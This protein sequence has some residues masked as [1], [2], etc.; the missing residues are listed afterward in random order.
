L[1][2]NFI[3]TT[4]TNLN[5][6]L[7]SQTQLLTY[8]NH[9]AIAHS[10]L[11]YLHSPTTFRRYKNGELESKPTPS[12]ILGTM[13]EDY[14]V[15]DE[16]TFH[17]KYVA[18]PVDLKTPSTEQQKNF[19]AY[20]LN[21]PIHT[22]EVLLDAYQY[23]Y[24]NQMSAAK[25]LEA[26]QKLAASLEEYVEFE[27]DT[28]TKVPASNFSTVTS[29][30]FNLKQHPVYKELFE[31]ESKDVIYHLTLGIDEGVEID[32]INWKAELDFVVIDHI[33]QCIYL[34]DLKTTGHPIGNFQYSIK[35][36]KYYRQLAHYYRMLQKYFENSL[37]KEWPIYVRIMAVETAYDNEAGFF[38]IPFDIIRLGLTELESYHDKIKFYYQTNFTKR[39]EE[40]QAGL[41]LIDWDKLKIEEWV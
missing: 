5:E 41:L 7:G 12:Q 24:S 39:F 14:I 35:S 29:M 15:M 9:P 6:T 8:R 25:K 32:G 28:R 18:I 27:K 36:Y 21:Y 2:L 4:E 37:Y 11:S 23:A 30:A 38:P 19:L 13:F 16:A 40:N 1:Y 20:I 31:S 3:M 10:D 34:I 22:D 17:N 26:A 33:G